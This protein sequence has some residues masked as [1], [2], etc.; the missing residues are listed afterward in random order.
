VGVQDKQEGEKINEEH[1]KEAEKL[2]G[3]MTNLDGYKLRTEERDAVDKVAQ[4]LGHYEELYGQ[5]TDNYH[6]IQEDKEKLD[7][8]FEELEETL[9]EMQHEHEADLAA[10]NVSDE[11]AIQTKLIEK[12]SAAELVMALLARLEIEFM[13][14]KDVRKVAA[15]EG[16]LVEFTALSK[17]IEELIPQAAKSATERDGDLARISTINGLMGEYAEQLQEVIVAELEAQAETHEGD[18][19][20]STVIQTVDEL[21]HQAETQ[22]GQAKNIANVM[23][24][25]TI[26]FALVAGGLLAVII[27][28]AVAGPL[29]N[30]IT[31]LTSGS[32]QVAVASA[33]VSEASQQL[34]EGSAEQASSLEEISSS[35]EEMASMT[36]QNADN[37]DQANGLARESRDASKA[38]NEAT[39]RM[40]GAMDEI[41]TAAEETS[42]I[43]KTI[44]EIAFQTNLLALNAAVEAARA[45]E[46][47][48]GFAVVA[49]EVRN[50]AQR[51]GEAARN[52]SALIE[53][54]VAKT[55]NG[56]S[57]AN[58]MAT[59]LGNITTSTAKVSD[60]VAEIAAASKEQAQGIEQVNVAVNQM[61]RVTQG[62]A[63]NAEETASASEEL[64][65]Q[66][67][68]MSEVVGDLMELM[69]GRTA[70][71][72][73]SNGAGGGST[74]VSLKMDHIKALD[75]KRQNGKGNAAGHFM[76]ALQPKQHVEHMAALVDDSG[77][78]EEF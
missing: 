37:A 22:A 64:N 23:S 47:G 59:S 7:A 53:Q 38:G 78:F 49:E 19:A 5:I 34:A 75:K 55:G 8:E 4:A 56:V 21:A 60:L 77:N 42:K 15:M 71:A 67:E 76:A 30:A 72:A 12:L 73:N 61:D 18:A 33:Q 14:D 25:I 74:H 68:S 65:A 57:I 39:Q 6:R 2:H 24:I 51:A 27:S 41:K 44:D 48:K 63:S 52:T 11:V 40:I 36:Q 43:I 9:A 1:G 35:L 62:S 28:R 13:Q 58:E 20:V 66:A 17:E 69:G 70:S 46:A 54:S 31:Q 29:G 50:L 10:L 16:L 3:V 32:E 45:G 26:L